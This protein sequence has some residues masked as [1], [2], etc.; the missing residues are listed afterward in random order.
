MK[1]VKATQK[2][3]PYSSWYI[4]LFDNGRYR[5][6]AVDDVHEKAYFVI[7]G[8][9]AIDDKFHMSISHAHRTFDSDEWQYIT[10]AEYLLALNIL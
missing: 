2:G 7:I 4:Q 10:E 9:Y 5:A 6:T 3:H 8:R 1:Y